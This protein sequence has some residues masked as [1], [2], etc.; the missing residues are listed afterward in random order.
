MAENEDFNDEN[1][2]DVS[3]NEFGVNRLNKELKEIIKNHDIDELIKYLKDIKNG[4]TDNVL[5]MS[6]TFIDSH[7]KGVELFLELAV[8]LEPN[9]S[10]HHYNYAIHLENQKSYK[11]AKKEYETA[12]KLENN[13]ADYFADYGN[14]L[15][16]LKDYK[17]AE[18]RYLKAVD[19][20]PENAS[21]WTNLGILYTNKEEEG[22]AEIALKKAISIDPMS[23]LSYLNLF[24][25]YVTNGRIDEAKKIIQKYKSL[26]IND[27]NLNIMHLD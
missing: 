7:L 19:I 18:K 8:K 2:N 17:G 3:Q 10:L 6:S 11:L 4:N 1:K 20:D 15:L 22:K 27:L 13:N 21:I 5:D 23:S 12:I 26:K 14:L 25:L 24:R 9:N 16:S